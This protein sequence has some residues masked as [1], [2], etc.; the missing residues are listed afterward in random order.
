MSDL[1]ARLFHI[2]Y[3]PET[4]AGI[5][6]GFELLDNLANPRPDWFEYW[7]IRQWLTSQTLD[8]DGFYGFFSPKFRAKT[9]LGPAEL[10]RH[11]EAHGAQ[12]DV[13]LY[14][15]FP[16]QIACYLN[17]FEQGEVSHPGFMQTCMDV[18]QA[19]GQPVALPGLV[20]DS[21]QMVYSNCFVARPAFW[22]EWLRWTQAVFLL[23]EAQDSTL[24]D[25]LQAPTAYAGSV[26]IKVFLIERIASLLLA[27]QPR[28][29][30]A[31]HSPFGHRHASEP[32][33]GSPSLLLACDAL[34]LAYR[35]QPF[36]QYLQ[37]FQSLRQQIAAG[38]TPS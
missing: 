11:I 10:R 9:G 7:P 3:S 18:L 13:L 31:A 36:P 24:K 30:V 22:R 4:K 6:D 33:L 2:A 14:S 29:R 21:R 35:Q 1:R 5:E 34:K 19:I 28:W 17:I 26:Q 32:D 37:A 15:P 27:L 16:T 12:A 20:M 8:E 25:R 38:G 23:A